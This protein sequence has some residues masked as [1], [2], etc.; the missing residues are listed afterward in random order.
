MKGKGLLIVLLVGMV[1]LAG[2]LGSGL[3]LARGAEGQSGP[4]AVEASDLE[5]L[6]E[7]LREAGY[8]VH[9]LGEIEDPF[10]A[11][12]AEAIEVNGEYVQVYVFEGEAAA[13][14]AAATVSGGGTMV[15]ESIV[16]WIEPPHFYEH[17]KLI[18]I[19][20]GR[21]EAVLEG[22]QAILGE[23]FLVGVSMG[24]PAPGGE[25]GE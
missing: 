7:A 16:D 5:T 19:Y 1:L 11:G 9:N 8:T 25:A 13:G 15:G 20:A 3:L 6:I 12:Q 17:G 22:L 14:E 18:V 10:F 23:P 4:G 21:D 2:V 24:L